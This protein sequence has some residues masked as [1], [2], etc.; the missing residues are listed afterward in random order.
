[1][2]SPFGARKAG[3]ESKH[4]SLDRKS[5][6]EIMGIAIVMVLIMIGILFVIQFIVVPEGDNIKKTYSQKELSSNFL[7]AILKTTTSCNNMRMTELIQDCA[8]NYGNPFQENCIDS[9]R[10]ICSNPNG[11]KSCDFLNRS[12]YYIT[13]KTLKNMS[14]KFELYLCKY[15]PITAKCAN[16]PGDLLVNISE[17][18]CSRPVGNEVS[19]LN[20]ISQQI[21]VQT[22]VGNRIL[23]INVC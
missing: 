9:T 7:N 20:I 23:V 13:D 1:M 16:R 2:K 3:S 22:D 21:P 19:A 12:L 17:N 18:G 4:H 14:L 10:I 6:A 11:C 15:D 5:Q 8:E